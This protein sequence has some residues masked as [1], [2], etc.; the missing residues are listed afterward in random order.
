MIRRYALLLAVAFTRV[1]AQEG[2][3]PPTV[4]VDVRDAATGQGVA[5]ARV[6]APGTRRRAVT[7]SAGMASLV[8]DSTRRLLVTSR[9]GFRPDTTVLTDAM[10]TAGIVAVKLIPAAQV[11]DPVPI[12]GTSPTMN[13][14]M[15]EF[16]GR[17]RRAAGGATFIGPE[18]FATSGLP[19]VTDFLRRGVQGVTLVDS[20]GILL[21]ASSRG[22]MLRLN[23]GPALGGNPMNRRSG[24]RT[25]EM[26]RVHCI[27][28][29]AV[30]GVPKEWGFDLRLIDPRE[31]YGMEI[32][33]GPST[34]PAQ[35]QSMGRDGFCGL[36][37][38]W[39]RPR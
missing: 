17:R 25:G 12:A 16:E 35:Y 3:V 5:G 15:L 21:P 38:L 10:W 32:Y 7:D 20:A 33:A 27:L 1:R 30:D 31:V 13:A 34:I 14:M 23:Q 11:L 18:Q 28:R 36:I 8:I 24:G 4:W 19:R 9:I 26:E 37:L 2:G 22:A 39:T 6:E 29:V